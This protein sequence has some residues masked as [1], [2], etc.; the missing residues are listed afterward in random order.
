VRETRLLLGYSLG[1]GKAGIFLR[2]SYP[3][4]VMRRAPVWQLM[5]GSTM[6]LAA[7]VVA[8]ALSLLYTFA[9]ARLLPP[10]AYSALVALISFAGV[11]SAP[12]GTVQTVVARYVAAGGKDDGRTPATIA[13]LLQLAAAATVALVLVCLTAAGVLARYLRLPSAVPVLWTV[14]L[15]AAVLF[16]PSL[17]GAVQGL[18]RFGILAAL[19]TVD[20][21]F[22][23]VLGL[24]LIA[25]GFGT[26][27]A[28][29]AM[30][31]GV[32]A[33]VGLTWLALPGEWR[34]ALWHRSNGPMA[35][36][37]T[38]GTELAP[39]LRFFV[40]VAGVSAGLVGL[41]LLDAI[42]ARHYLSER[43]AGDY[44]AVAVL[45]RGLFWLSGA[46]ATVVVPLAARRTSGEA[47]G[48]VIGPALA[49]TAAVSAAGLLCFALAPALLMATLFGPTYAPAAPL[50][51]RYGWAAVAL[52]FANV[53]ANYALGRGARQAG[54]PAVAALLLFAALVVWRHQD[55]GAI[56]AALTAAGV[57]MAGGE[58]LVVWHLERR[59]ERRPLPDYSLY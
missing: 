14:P 44:A 52:A 17:R 30:A 39:L 51:L 49:V 48:S 8:S 31:A 12:A 33:G 40:P 56:V 13:L 15:A 6:L 37:Q 32:L 36:E 38:S 35:R 3:K 23:V 9:A 47:A 24:A 26:S 54:L 50:L 25:L 57:L 41:V 10:D 19:A 11:L 43:A 4:E 28:M 18:C 53:L 59:G 58:A 42:V 7:S 55:G 2:L 22:K 5:R 34:P 20:T 21:L 16:L 1:R 46:V 45:G 29:A 27:G